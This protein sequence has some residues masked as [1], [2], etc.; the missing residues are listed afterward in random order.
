MVLVLC[1]WSVAISSFVIRHLSLGGEF[2]AA[3]RYDGR[4]RLIVA[5][6]AMDT[7]FMFLGL[8]LFATPV[9]YPVVRAFRTRIERRTRHDWRDRELTMIDW[10]NFSG[11]CM[12]VGELTYALGMFLSKR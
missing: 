1:Q 3:E 5:R 8:G 12:F 2:I 4:R 9:W 11:I 6:C 10:L 7:F